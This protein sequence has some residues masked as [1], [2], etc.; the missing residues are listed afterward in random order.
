MLSGSDYYSQG[1]TVIKEAIDYDLRLPCLYDWMCEE[2]SSSGNYRPPEGQLFKK[3]ATNPMPS[4]L[5]QQLG[6]ILLT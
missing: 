6:C 4:E 5:Q 3:T 1:A 2:Y